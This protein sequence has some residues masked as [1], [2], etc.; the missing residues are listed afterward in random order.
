M[1]ILVTGANG[2][3]GRNLCLQLKQKGEEVLEFDRD[4]KEPLEQLVSQAG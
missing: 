4:T 1:K 3:I 2:F